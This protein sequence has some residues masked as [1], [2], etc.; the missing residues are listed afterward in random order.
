MKTFLSLFILLTGFASGAKAT[1]WNPDARLLDAVCQ[2]ESSGGRYVYGDNGLSL[3]HFQIQKA[4]WTDVSVWRQKRNL[5]TYDYQ[6]E[7]LNPQI[8]RIYAAD[9][10]AIIYGRLREKYG[11][12]PIPSELYAAYNMGLN[13]FRRCNYDISKVNPITAGK[14]RQL[15][16]LLK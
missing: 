8:N 5:A 3:G 1:T 2:I 15:E 16:A 7:V 11:R 10:I 6:K 13:N 12:S 14:C 9:Y 4:A